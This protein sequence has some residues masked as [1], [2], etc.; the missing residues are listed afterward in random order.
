MDKRVGV[1]W[2][3]RGTLGPPSCTSLEGPWVIENA[4]GKRIALLSAWGSDEQESMAC[5]MAAAPD[6]L[7]ALMLAY[8]K[9]NP[10]GGPAK[11][12]EAAA[13]RIRAGESLTEVMD[14]YGLA[15]TSPAK[16][17]AS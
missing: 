5:L 3:A 8:A 6:L 7:K 11:V 14:D 12:F 2:H 15:W 10:L 1:S 9:A 16:R 4:D 17:G 13:Q